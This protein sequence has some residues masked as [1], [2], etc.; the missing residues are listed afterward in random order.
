MTVLSR[1]SLHARHIKIYG[2]LKVWRR[3]QV[4]G[5]TLRY[6]HAGLPLG[7]IVLLWNADAPSY[8]AVDLGTALERL[9][10]ARS[11]RPWTDLIHGRMTGTAPPAVLDAIRT[12]TLLLGHGITPSARGAGN[13]TRRIAATIS[14]TTASLGFSTAVRA[15]YAYWDGLSPLAT[16]WPE[17]TGQLEQEVAH[18]LRP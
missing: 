13:I 2:H 14:Q 10:W 17:V 1:L 5:I 16:S 7:D 9:A 18:H 15:S 6:D 4:E 12:A 11:R 3:R 8:L